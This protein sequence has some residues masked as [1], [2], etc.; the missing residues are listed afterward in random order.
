M[1]KE[2]KVL[3]EL[4]KKCW[5][6]QK[7]KE[8]LL[9]SDNPVSLIEEITDT[10]INLP[11]GTRME[12]VDQTNSGIVYLNIPAEPD[13]SSLELNEE[14]LEMVAGGRLSELQQMIA[15]KPRILVI[16]DKYPGTPI[17]VQPPNKGNDPQ[18]SAAIR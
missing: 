12:V 9:N 7:F 6:D 13:V 5:A 2:Q 15:I 1:S 16:E 11:E 8:L 10:V 3:S 14:E 17:I 4:I 18:I